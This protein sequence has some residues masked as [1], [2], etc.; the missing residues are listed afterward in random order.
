VVML[1]G[2]MAM[3]PAII[4]ADGTFEWTGLAPRRYTLVWGPS[5]NFYRK[6]IEFNHQ[7]L[8]DST[9][10]LTQ[11][12]GGTLDIVVAPNAATIAAKVPDGKNVR[13]TLWSDVS[14]MDG[15][16]DDNGAVSFT[17][18]APGEYRILAWQTID[19]EYAQIREL[20]ARFDAQ[21]ITLA[22]GAHE[23][24]AVKLVPKSASDA[25]IAKLQ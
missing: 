25:E 5:E 7:P 24:V 21:K 12:S 22:E 11:G 1:A 6:S 16:T 17:N 2:N 4:G 13:V 10:D 23:S 19:R 8:A 14:L 3:K 20:L 18:L 15:R 9:I